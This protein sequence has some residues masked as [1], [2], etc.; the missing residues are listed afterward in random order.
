MI[1]FLILLSICIIYL[2]FANLNLEFYFSKTNLLGCFI[3][4][5][6]SAVMTSLILH[7]FKLSKNLFIRILQ[8]FVIYSVLYTV[9]VLFIVTQVYCDPGDDVTENSYLKSN[10]VLE[11]G[12]Y[13]DISPLENLLGYQ[14]T[15]NILI[16]IIL[17]ILSLKR[18]NE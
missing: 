11:T 13:P 17:I 2:F 18:R 6:V 14:V 12:D 4:F 3:S 7:K 8:L 16:F 15:L 10:S 5:F 1:S 9:I